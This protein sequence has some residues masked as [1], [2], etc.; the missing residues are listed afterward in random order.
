MVVQVLL[1]FTVVA[2]VV[3][4]LGVVAASYAGTTLALQRFF[5]DGYRDGREENR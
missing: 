3:F 5:E 4:L 1:S 2:A